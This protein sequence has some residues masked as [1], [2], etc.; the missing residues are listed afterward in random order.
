MYICHVVQASP[1][2]ARVVFMC[3]IRYIAREEWLAD[4]GQGRACSIAHQTVPHVQEDDEHCILRWLQEAMRWLHR[5]I[6]IAASGRVGKHAAH[7]R[8]PS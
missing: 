7:V 6:S 5:W 1:D 3:D 8:R 4:N 2:R